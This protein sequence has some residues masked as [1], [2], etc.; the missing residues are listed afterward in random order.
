[1]NKNE[2][3]EFKNKLVELRERITD[4]IRNKGKDTL[5]KSQREAS[6]DLSAYAFH[7]ADVASDSFEREMS[8]DRVSAEQKVLYHIDDALKRIE[9]GSYGECETCKKK[10]KKERL[11]AIP[12][13]TLCRACKQKHEEQR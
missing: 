1:M 12:Y 7:M 4:D 2:S 13:A 11:K 10:I 9:S 5:S 3:K 6:G 8:W